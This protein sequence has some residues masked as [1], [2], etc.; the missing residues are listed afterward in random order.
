MENFYLY[1]MMFELYNSEGLYNHL[2]L[3]FCLLFKFLVSAHT[4]YRSD[5]IRIML[6]SCAKMLPNSSISGSHTTYLIW[7]FLLI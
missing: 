3:T 5:F 1:D 4:Y 2:N 6:A 7:I